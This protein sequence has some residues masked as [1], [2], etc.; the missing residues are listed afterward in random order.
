MG[1]RLRPHSWPIFLA[2]LLL[3]F[4]LAPFLR[5]LDWAVFDAQSRLLRRTAPLPAPEVVLV[6]ID[7]A[8]EAYPE[9]IAMWHAHLGATLEAL[10]EGR[11]RAVGLDLNLPTRSYDAFHP[12]LD[13]ALMRGLLG[14]RRVC[15]LVLGATVDASGDART[16][17]PPFVTAVGGP[18]GQGLVQWSVDEDAVVRRFTERFPGH[19]EAEPTLAGQIARRLAFPVPAGLLDYRQG[20]PVP[21]LPLQQV[22]AWGRAGDRERLLKAFQGRVVLVGTVVPFEDRH[23]QVMDLNGWGEEN[24]GFAPG[25][26]LHVQ[27][28]RNLLGRGLIGEIPGW[29][30]GGLL[31][32]ATLGG[33]AAS[34][35]ARGGWMLLGT[36][37]LLAGTGLALQGKGWWLPPAGPAFGL[38]LGFGLPSGW[39]AAAKLRE[40]AR[41]RSVFGGYVSPGVLAEILAGRLQADF[42]GQRTRLCVLFSDVRGFTTL[43]EGRSPEEIIAMLN[44]YFERMAPAVHAA[45]G[46]VVSYIGDGLMAHFGHPASLENPCRAAF[47]ASKAMLASLA[48]LNRDFRAEGLPELRIGI[49]LHVGEAV[50]G[51]IGSRE[52]HEYTAIGDTVNV[53]ARV[54]GLSKEA[55]H[56]LVLTAAVAAQ[57]PG[58]SLAPLGAKPIKGHTPMEVFGWGGPGAS[59]A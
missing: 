55:G 58:E 22:E 20:G 35:C 49:G 31:A 7:E 56:P 9:P 26:L 11:P 27:A 14:L 10:A 54:E 13:A 29:I 45:G 38:L 32:L 17:H 15:P 8:T 33:W 34:R 23:H 42:Q 37:V 41:L 5:R 6:G 19:R 57:L 4:T 1:D 12:G 48:E 18:T 53:A 40:R 24:R 52:R 43:S 39:E 30:L 51:H 36:G 44:R 3:A 47:E 16:I 50:V 25:V 59:D 28:L 2:A 46:T 21:Y